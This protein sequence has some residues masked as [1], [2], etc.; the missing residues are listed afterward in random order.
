VDE[1][2]QKHK[3]CSHAGLILEVTRQYA[4]S[5]LSV[6]KRLLLLQEHQIIEIKNGTIKRK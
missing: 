1:A 2:I 4:V 3:Q 6:K 5:V